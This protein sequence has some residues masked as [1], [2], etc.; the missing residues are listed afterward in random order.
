MIT[1]WGHG[2]W[3]NVVDVIRC[4][5]IHHH[6]GIVLPTKPF[7]FCLQPPVIKLLWV[8]E[9]HI[10]DKGETCYEEHVLNPN[11]HIVLHNHITNNS[12][13]IYI[14]IHIYIY[15]IIFEPFSAYI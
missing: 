11:I 15:I 2:H 14:Y 3:G 6:H 10:H 12:I 7:A 9:F 5:K 4:G 1:T 13:Y 8:Y